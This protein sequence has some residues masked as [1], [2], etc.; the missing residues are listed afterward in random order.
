MHDWTDTSLPEPLRALRVA[1]FSLEVR[2]GTRLTIRFAIAPPSKL[3][4]Y[5]DCEAEPTAGGSVI[6][7]HLR[8]PWRPRTAALLVLAL[9]GVQMVYELFTGTFDRVTVIIAIVVPSLT[10]LLAHADNRMIRTK[11]H[12][13]MLDALQTALGRR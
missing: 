12:A 13:G 9:L 10:A 2:D 7:F 8:G 5:C 4:R 11:Y 1:R 3:V 6:R